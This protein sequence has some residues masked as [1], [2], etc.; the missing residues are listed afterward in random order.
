MAMPL[1]KIR[2]GDLVRKANG[3]KKPIDCG[4]D[5]GKMCVI[6]G[7]CGLPDIFETANE[8][9]YQAL[10]NYSLKDAVLNKVGIS[11]LLQNFV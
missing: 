1:E 7:A 9:Y 2:L 4:K 10:N 5:S 3:N 6:H 11:R 8:A